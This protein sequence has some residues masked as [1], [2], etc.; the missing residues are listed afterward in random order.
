MN[1]LLG[2]AVLAAMVALC[3]SSLAESP[4]SPLRLGPSVG[5]PQWL[6]P[7]PSPQSATPETAPTAAR[8]ERA[9]RQAESTPPDRSPRRS[10]RRSARYSRGSS[11]SMAARLNR[12]ELN[13]I[14]SGGGSY[15]YRSY[16]PWSGY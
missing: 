13:R 3:G 7:P 1:R 2:G 9:P 16:G 14:R 12:Q 4:M 6:E 11:D 15:Y 8:E 5:S 10:E